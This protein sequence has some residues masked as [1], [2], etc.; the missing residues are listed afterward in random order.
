MWDTETLTKKMP[1]FPGSWPKAGMLCQWDEGL[2][3]QVC[4]QGLGLKTLGL[5]CGLGTI[6]ATVLG[7]NTD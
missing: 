1:K 2:A 7:S 3:A 5:I 4:E 6:T